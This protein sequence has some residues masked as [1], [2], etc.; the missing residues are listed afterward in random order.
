MLSS[1]HARRLVAVAARSFTSSTAMQMGC[2]T[3]VKKVGI[4]G[5]G[6]MGHGIHHTV[7]MHIYPRLCCLLASEL[8][9]KLFCYLKNSM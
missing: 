7:Y 6:L 1:M 8:T 5:L 3:E 9:F 2:V 4:V